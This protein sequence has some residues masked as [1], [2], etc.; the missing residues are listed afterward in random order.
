MRKAMITS[1]DII[2]NMPCIK[3]SLPSNTTNVIYHP[4]IFNSVFSRTNTKLIDP[5][6]DIIKNVRCTTPEI[7]KDVNVIIPNIFMKGDHQAIMCPYNMIP[8]SYLRKLHMVLNGDVSI[9]I[10]DIP[11][12]YLNKL[13]NRS[14]RL[15]RDVFLSK[16]LSISLY[17]MY[18]NTGNEV[19]RSS[20]VQ[21]M[22]TT[23]KIVDLAHKLTV[24]EM[25][26]DIVHHVMDR[27]KYKGMLQSICRKMM[28]NDIE[29]NLVMLN[30]LSLCPI[31]KA[32]LIEHLV[33][34]HGYRE[35]AINLLKHMN[36]MT[37]ATNHG[38]I[39]SYKSANKID[40][41]LCYPDL[42]NN[43]PRV[44]SALARRME[45]NTFD[46]DVIPYRVR[47]EIAMMYI[48]MNKMSF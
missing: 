5:T 19:F 1:L 34:I 48:L 29:L 4:Y 20:V 27:I 2:D 31:R 35:V 14:L 15:I 11:A 8:H 30:T 44:Y 17:Y 7:L 16:D 36:L 28:S 41:I 13:D 10:T 45:L 6:R 46:I 24:N 38:V 43:N 42:Y 18:V 25:K 3:L 9:E 40:D 32:N 39:T 37:I 12:T 26:C 21:S 33:V 22:K 23:K 47:N